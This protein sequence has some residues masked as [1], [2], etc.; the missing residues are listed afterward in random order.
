MTKSKIK[1]FRNYNE[2][3]DDE[4]GGYY[5]HREHIKEKHLKSALRSKNL[6]AL[7]NLEDDY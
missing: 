7:L 3:Y 5:D 6:D 4:A 1:R 2:D